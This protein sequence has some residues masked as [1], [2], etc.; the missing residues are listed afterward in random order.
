L[1]QK[2]VNYGCKK[3]YSTGP[4]SL[5][6]CIVVAGK[7]HLHGRFFTAIWHC[8][9]AIFKAGIAFL[10]FLEGCDG[11]QPMHVLRGQGN[12]ID[13]KTQCKIALQ[14]PDV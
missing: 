4:L 9:F 6:L 11:P 10:P 1:L 3:F 2:S 13:Y 7:M 14:K 12:L 8:V 5:F